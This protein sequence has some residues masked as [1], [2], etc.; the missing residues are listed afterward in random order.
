MGWPWQGFLDSAADCEA[1][2]AGV[3]EMPAVEWFACID[4]TA[5]PMPSTNKAII[6]NSCNRMERAGMP[7]VYRWP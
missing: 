7:Q 1:E 3:S 5:T 6:K 4:A 2:S